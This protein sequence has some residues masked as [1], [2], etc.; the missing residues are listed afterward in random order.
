MSEAGA[1][2]RNRPPVAKDKNAGRKSEDGVPGPAGSRRDSHGARRRPFSGF[3]LVELLVVITIIGILIALLLPA[4]QSA[5]E[6]ARRAQCQNNLKQLGLGMLQHVEVHG[7]FPSGGWGFAWVGDPDRGFGPGQPGG[8]IY[9][10]LPFIEQEALH[11]FG[12]G[13]DDAQRKTA[14]ATV[15][16][17]ALPLVNCPSRRR[18]TTFVCVHGDFSGGPPGWI[19]YNADLVPRAARSDYAANAG[20]RHL[21]NPI[22]PSSLAVGDSQGPDQWPAWQKEMTGVSYVRSRVQPA[23]VRDSMSNTY[24]IGEKNLDP[25]HYLDG[26]TAADNRGMYQGHD[27]DVYRWAGTEDEIHPH[28]DRAGDSTTQFAFGSAHVT[29]FHACLCDGSVRAIRYS[30]NP[31]IHQRLGNRED[32]QPVDHSE[33]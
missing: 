20:D 24:L 33:L 27:Y 19:G 2:G 29:G 12:A 1:G 16:Q 22:G 25:L 8:W 11:Q 5:R 32:D 10:T 21:E 23:H 28:R 30:I 3:T 14:A 18:A 17:T 13:G 31:K 26:Q 7:F 4:V 9:D 15:A 6:A